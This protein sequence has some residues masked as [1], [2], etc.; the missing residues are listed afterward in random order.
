[1]VLVIT[2]QTQYLQQLHRLVA[3]AVGK[4]T[5]QRQRLV[6]LVAVAVAMAMSQEPLEPQIKDMRVE[7]VL[8]SQKYLVA[9]V[10]QAQ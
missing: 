10:A 6:D 2:D 8:L 3:V 5:A 7:M 1:V 4:E 9:V